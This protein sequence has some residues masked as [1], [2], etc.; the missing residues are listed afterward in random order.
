MQTDLF[1]H[2]T[3]RTAYLL[4]GAPA[5]TIM[6]AAP[7]YGAYTAITYLP[8]GVAPASE[9]ELT[10]LG[11]GKVAFEAE[12]GHGPTAAQLWKLTG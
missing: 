3:T 9:L 2:G 8:G 5:A 7:V 10:Y 12:G 1:V 11:N 6:T 4:T